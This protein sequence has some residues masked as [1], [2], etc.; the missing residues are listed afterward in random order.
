MNAAL[1]AL[2]DAT[3]EAEQH[4]EENDEADDIDGVLRDIDRE[5]GFKA[6]FKPCCDGADNAAHVWGV[7][8]SAWKFEEF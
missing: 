5:E 4:C 8:G 1:A 3:S 6:A 7:C 2:T